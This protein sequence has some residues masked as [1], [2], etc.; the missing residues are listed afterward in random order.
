MTAEAQA[1]IQA[2]AMTV[3]EQLAQAVVASLEERLDNAVATMRSSARSRTGGPPTTSW[4]KQMTPRRRWRSRDMADRAKHTADSARA[5]REKYH[6][7]NGTLT[8]ADLAREFGGSP[9]T[10]S[11]IVKGKL[12]PKAGGPI[13]TSLKPRFGRKAPPVEPAA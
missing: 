4:V 2:Q 10:I 13:D 5:I 12:W 9:M 1:A 3:E 8:F 6:A 7:A 11:L